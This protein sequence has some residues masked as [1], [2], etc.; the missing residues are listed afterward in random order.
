VGGEPGDD[1]NAEPV[2]V[3]GDLSQH[4]FTLSGIDTEELR[5]SLKQFQVAF[6]MVTTSSFTA[7]AGV[8]VPTIRWRMPGPRRVRLLERRSAPLPAARSTPSSA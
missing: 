1:R 2:Q 4:Q 6:R 5:E 8:R 3:I 7:W